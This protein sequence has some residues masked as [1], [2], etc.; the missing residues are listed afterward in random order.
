MVEMIHSNLR[1]E[2]SDFDRFV[3]RVL[4]FVEQSERPSA[5]Y[6]SSELK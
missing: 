3:D 2:L 6:G 5:V 4:A 1:S